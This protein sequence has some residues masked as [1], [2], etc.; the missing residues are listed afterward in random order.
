MLLD[1]Y[2]ERLDPLLLDVDLVDNCI[3]QDFLDYWLS[4]DLGLLMWV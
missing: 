3:F 1:P 4:T 2:T